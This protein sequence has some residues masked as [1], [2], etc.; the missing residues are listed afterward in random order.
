MPVVSN[1]G[2]L[3]REALYW[4]FPHYHSDGHRPS[5]AI[6]R[7]DLKPIPFF[8]TDRVRL[9]NLASDI[10]ERHD[11]AGDNPDE[12]KRLLEMLTAW[13]GEVNARTV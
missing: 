9:Y 3:D 2:A 4:H 6:R 11:L 13:R 7:G 8:E 1:T 12:A 5:G 10:G